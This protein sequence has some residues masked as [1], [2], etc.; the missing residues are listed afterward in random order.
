MKRL[1]LFASIAKEFEDVDFDPVSVFWE[2][3]A[4]LSPDPCLGSRLMKIGSRPPTL[5]EVL[6]LRLL[7]VALK[8]LYPSEQQ[9]ATIVAMGSW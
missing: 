6:K 5:F 2:N 7:Q 3:Q 4:P 9:E 1:E 8:K